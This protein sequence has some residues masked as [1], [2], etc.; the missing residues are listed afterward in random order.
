MVDDDDYPDKYQE[1]TSTTVSVDALDVILSNVSDTLV[2]TLDALGAVEEDFGCAGMC[3]ISSLYS[4]S[5]TAEGLPTQNCSVA[6]VNF[7]IEVGK[8]TSIWSWIF[9]IPLLFSAIFT[10]FLWNKKHSKIESPLLGH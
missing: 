2:F 3:T 7:A 1:C 6:I 4:F 9:G 5:D 10:C 8:K